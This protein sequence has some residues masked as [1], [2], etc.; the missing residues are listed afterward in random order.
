MVEGDKG[1]EEYMK[2]RIKGN[3]ERKIK[4]KEKLQRNLKKKEIIKKKENG[5]SKRGREVAE[6]PKIC[7]GFPNNLGIRL[8]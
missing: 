8:M 2:K 3:G 6:C 4:E 5:I 7:L 1:I